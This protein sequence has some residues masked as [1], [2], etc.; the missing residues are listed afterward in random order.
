MTTLKHFTCISSLIL[1]TVFKLYYC[2]HFIDKEV[3]TV[4]RSNSM[5][6]I[7]GLVRARLGFEYNQGLF[8]FVSQTLKHC[9]SWPQK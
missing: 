8:E 9:A 6:N 2:P 7:T 5:S 4:K 1:I 3:K